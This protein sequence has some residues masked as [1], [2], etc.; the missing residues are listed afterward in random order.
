MI[1]YVA[2]RALPSIPVH[3][4]QVCDKLIAIAVQ[5]THAPSCPP[6][7]LFSLQNHKE[8][9]YLARSADGLRQTKT[10]PDYL[11]ASD[12]ELGAV[13]R[14]LYGSKHST[15]QHRFT[16]FLL[17]LVCALLQQCGNRDSPTIWRYYLRQV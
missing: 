7:D 10:T 5:C 15:S 14:P 9:Y 1:T 6:T 4:G 16:A 8:L 12:L 3:L 11:E 17:I 2:G 13:P